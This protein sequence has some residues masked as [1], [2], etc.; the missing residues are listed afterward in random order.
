MTSKQLADQL[1]NNNTSKI[2]DNLEGLGFRMVDHS[3]FNAIVEVAFM[4]GKAEGVNETYNECTNHL[5]DMDER[6][7]EIS[8]KITN[9]TV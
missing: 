7:I 4:M 6:V 3:A 1:W 5:L 2:N 9:A 8:D